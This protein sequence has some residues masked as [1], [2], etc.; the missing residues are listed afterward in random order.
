MSRKLTDEEE[1]VWK[2]ATAGV[3]QKKTPSAKISKIGTKFDEELVGAKV[4][5]PPQKIEKPVAK[6]PINA[7][8]LIPNSQSLAPLNLGNFA[9][10]DAA[11][12]RRI[13]R[14]QLAVSAR[15]DLH[16]M[17]QAEAY[18]ELVEFIEHASS[19]NKRLVLVITGKGRRSESRESG[20]LKAMLPRWL[21]LPEL[22]SNILAFDTAQIMH[23][24]SGAFYILL[25][26]NRV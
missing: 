16:G 17:T 24:G 3:K 1:R 6:N 9:G 10:V 5:I 21:N 13:K 2:Q 18:R 20:V 12:V 14:G 26:R 8:D 7:S 23:G 22:R 4:N 19:Q 15:V 11:T 25:K